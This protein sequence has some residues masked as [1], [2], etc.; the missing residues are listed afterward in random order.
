MAADSE[1]PVCSLTLLSASERRELLGTW[2]GGADFAVGEGLAEAFE[3]VA[4][5]QGERKR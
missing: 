5:R 1:R 3:R 4:A 2:N